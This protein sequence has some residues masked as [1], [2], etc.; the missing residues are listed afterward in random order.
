MGTACSYLSLNCYLTCAP[1]PTSWCLVPTRPEVLQEL[2]E[3]PITISIATITENFFILYRFYYL[4]IKNYAILLFYLL[5]ILKSC[6]SRLR[7]EKEEEYIYSCF[8]IPTF[9]ILK[10]EA[11]HHEKNIVWRTRL[12]LN[13][14]DYLAKVPDIWLFVTFIRY[15]YLHGKPIK[16]GILLSH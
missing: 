15:F 16:T 7:S 11:A 14:N 12:K 1:T 6:L 5:Y 13:W 9:D 4:L 3:A 10:T 2:M 8:T